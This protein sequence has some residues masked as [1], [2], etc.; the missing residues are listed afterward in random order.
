M[1]KPTYRAIALF[2]VF[3][4]ALPAAAIDQH[5]RI[6]LADMLALDDQEALAEA[7][8][9]FTAVQSELFEA[10]SVLDIAKAD[11]AIV[12]GPVEEA[13]EELAAAEADLKD[14]I[15]AEVPDEEIL[16]LEDAVHGAKLWLEEVA[17]EVEPYEEAR[18]DAKAVFDEIKQ[19]YHEARRELSVARTEVVATTRFVE[20]LD[21]RRAGLLHGALIDAAREDLL[22]L[23]ID[24]DVLEL[25]S[26]KDLGKAEIEQLPFAF[27]RAREQGVDGT[28]V[29][30]CMIGDEDCPEAPPKSTRVPEPASALDPE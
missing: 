6:E 14:A 17:A 1:P 8:A 11:Y 18:A 28:A 23:D 12:A 30:L 3:F 27:E 7:D 29:F 5:D 19:R 10:E 2:S 20:K 4:L 16:D 22:P 15:A 21:D 26:A 9:A 25:I 24:V 13:T